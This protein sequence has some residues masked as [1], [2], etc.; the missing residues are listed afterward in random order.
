LPHDY[1]KYSTFFPLIGMTSF[2]FMGTHSPISI[3]G[4]HLAKWYE[5]HLGRYTE[6]GVWKGDGRAVTAAVL[7]DPTLALLIA[8]CR[9]LGEN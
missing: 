5:F 3:C 9:W 6:A 7:S 2:N 1:N 8:W 4:I